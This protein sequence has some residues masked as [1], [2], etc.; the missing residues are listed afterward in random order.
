M[1]SA[2]R[3]IFSASVVPTVGVGREGGRLCECV[4]G[5]GVGAESRCVCVLGG[6]GGN[7]PAGI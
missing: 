5:V 7:I 2:A 6:G 1:L 3:T 4:G